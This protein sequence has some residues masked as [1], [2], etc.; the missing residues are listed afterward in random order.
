MKTLLVLFVLIFAAASIRAQQAQYAWV[1]A[2]SVQLGEPMVKG[3]PFSGESINETIQTLSDGN[4]IIRRSSS[5]LFRDGEG[6]YRREDMPKQI[7]L[8]GT[9]I[10][11]PE[12]ISI[13]D[14]VAGFKYTLYPKTNTARKTP[15]RNVFDYKL[16]AD[17]DFKLQTQLYKTR[18]YAVRA[19]TEKQTAG[20]ANSGQNPDGEAVAR[21]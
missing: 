2:D 11:M 1:L 12:S 7:G 10:D 16:K 13:I 9:A 4:R 21:R 6:R 18:I 20:D 15:F 3:A 17:L 14:P 8:P 19:D 5:K